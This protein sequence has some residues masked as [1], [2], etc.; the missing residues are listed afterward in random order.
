MKLTLPIFPVLVGQRGRSQFRSFELEFE[1]L[2]YAKYCWRY[3]FSKVGTFSG[4]SRRSDVNMNKHRRYQVDQTRLQ[5]FNDS[6][7]GENWKYSTESK[8]S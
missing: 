4:P 6:L 5:K 7:C 3:E 8:L 2:R 1:L